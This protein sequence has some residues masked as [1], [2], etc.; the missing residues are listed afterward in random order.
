MLKMQAV[1]KLALDGKS[2]R[3]EAEKHLAEWHAGAADRAK[4]MQVYGE[5]RRARQARKKLVRRQG[6][7]A[8]PSCDSSSEECCGLLQSAD[9]AAEE[10]ARGRNMR[11]AA[12][13]AASTRCAAQMWAIIK[14]RNGKL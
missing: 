2:G 11:A 9:G 10:Y 3:F 7:C 12:T 8:D 4:D 13:A 14:R 6:A 5:E 1:D